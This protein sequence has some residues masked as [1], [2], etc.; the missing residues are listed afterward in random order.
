MKR[1]P[2][3]A[4]FHHEE[5]RFVLAA[6]IGQVYRLGKKHKSARKSKKLD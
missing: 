4:V 3:M 2:D 6:F 1:P 5:N